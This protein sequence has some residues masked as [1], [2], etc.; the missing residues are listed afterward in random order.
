M[1]DLRRRQFITLLGGAAAAWPLPARAQQGE[2]VR[3]IGLLM[4]TAD[5]RE[6]E[7]RVAALKRGLQ[8]LGWTD[9]RNIQI[10]TRF[11][12]ADTSRIRA[13]AAEL[14]ALAPDII[15]GQTTPVIRA[16]RQATSSIPIIMAAVTDPVGQGF[17]SSL[18]HPG[19]NI[20][21]YVTGFSQFE[22]GL[23]GEWLGVLKEVAPKVT[24]AAVIRDP[25]NAPGI[26]QFD[27]IQAV[28]PSL[29]VEVSPFNVRDAG[30]IERT[31]TAFSQSSNGGLIVTGSALAVVHRELIIA[32]AA[33]N[34]LPAVYFERLF[35]TRGG[36][37]SYGPDLLDQFR[38]AAGYVDRILK[39]AKP[40]DLPVQAPTRYDLAINLKTARALGLEIPSSVLA[41]ADEVIE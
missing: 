28:A 2:R 20:T 13:D 16:L 15:V 14:V 31:I 35:V 6:G 24:R 37:I 25:A 36:L 26:G 12:G 3:R 34:S 22:Y 7:T 23:S 32:L 38:R 41:R 10:E 5:D 11:G 9:G 1:L 39:G 33:R 17:V 21:G 4:G 8:E 29:G 19:G 40:A 18:A 30:E 27:A